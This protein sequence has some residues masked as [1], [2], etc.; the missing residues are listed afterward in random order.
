MLVMAMMIVVTMTMISFA[1]ETTS[2]VVLKT[3]LNIIQQNHFRL[4]SKREEN[5]SKKGKLFHKLIWP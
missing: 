5:G 3:V 4:N 1:N 2:K